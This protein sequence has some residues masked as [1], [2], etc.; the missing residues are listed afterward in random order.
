M[1]PLEVNLNKLIK[2]DALSSIS[3]VCINSLC[4]C[5]LWDGLCLHFSSEQNNLL[6]IA[7]NFPKNDRQLQWNTDLLTQIMNLMTL[8]YD[9]NLIIRATNNKRKP[10]LK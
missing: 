7:I 3:I 4:S 5:Q 8:I 9:K 2:R 6:L 10:T 1:S